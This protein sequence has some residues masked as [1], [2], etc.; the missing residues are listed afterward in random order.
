MRKLSPI[1]AITHAFN[2]VYTYRS[3]ALR[4]GMF[5]IPLL[6]LLGIMELAVG[7][8]DLEN[9]KFDLSMM[10]Q[11][12]SA[13]IGFIGF[14][15][16]AVS[17]HRFILRDEI[18]PAIQVDGPVLRYAGNSLLIMLVVAA[19]LAIAMVI[20]LLVPGAGVLLLPVGLI[21]GTIIT[22]LSIKLPAVA[23]GNPQFGF[24][25]AW[26]VSEGCFWPILGVFLLNVAIVFGIVLVLDVGVGALGS[27]SPAAAQ[28]FLV[29]AG[30]VLKL[31]L[32]LFNASIFT[33]LYGFFVERRD[34]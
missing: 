18:R 31:F 3:V 4:I 8:P 2:S 24:R 19:P 33:S 16:M 21:A 11:L 28:T 32:T 23:L 15:S 20:A 22:R 34:F 12:V 30:A 29:A 9:P 13:V 1:K 14:C 5:W 26:R 17:W 27:V 7:L 25:D 10:M 6:V